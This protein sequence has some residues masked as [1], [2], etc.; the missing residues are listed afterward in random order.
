MVRGDA[1]LGNAGKPR[2]EKLYDLVI[3]NARVVRPNKASVDCL[4]MAVMGG[5]I[6]RLAPD[7]QGEQ[8]KQ[9]VDAQK[10]LAFPGCVA[11]H[12]HIGIYAALAHHA[13]SESKAAALGGLTS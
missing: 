2:M 4:D 8:E 3:K 13:G 9:V 5:K 10:F 6:A 12:L 7:I 11:G 1:K